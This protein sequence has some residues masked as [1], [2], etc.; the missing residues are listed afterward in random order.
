MIYTSMHIN[1]IMVWTRD[2]S[3]QWSPCFL[4]PLCCRFN[5]TIGFP[6]LQFIIAIITGIRCN[7]GLPGNGREMSPGKAMWWRTCDS[8]FIGVKSIDDMATIISGMAI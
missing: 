1:T 8:P 6:V 2:S 5:G 4:Q 3:G 7:I